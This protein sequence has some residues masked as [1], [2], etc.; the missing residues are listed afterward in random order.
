MR[1]GPVVYDDERGAQDADGADRAVFVF[2]LEPVE[3]FGVA[4]VGWEVCDVA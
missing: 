3:E 4:V 2:V 1:E